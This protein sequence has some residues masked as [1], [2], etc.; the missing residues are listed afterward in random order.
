[1]AVSMLPA[2]LSSQVPTLLAVQEVSDDALV[3]LLEERP[4]LHDAV[5]VASAHSTLATGHVSAL[6]GADEPTFDRQLVND[7]GVRVNVGDLAVSS[8]PRGQLAME[9]PDEAPGDPHAIVDGYDEA[10]DRITHEIL[11]MLQ[12]SKVLVIWAFDQSESMKDDQAEIRA[13]VEK[14]YRELQLHGATQGDALLTA[15]ASF[16]ATVRLHTEKP[17]ADPDRIRAAI[18]E[19]PID[20]TGQ[21]MLCHAV[22]YLTRQFESAGTSGRRQVAL[23]LVTDESGDKQTNVDLLEAAIEQVRDAR[24]RIYVLGREA[25]FGYL[26]AHIFWRHPQTG[27]IHK[28]PIDRGPETAYAEQL[29]TNGLTRRYDSQPSGFGPY[30]QCRMVRQTGGVFFMLPSVETDIVRED[31]NAL[32]RY[33]NG[34]ISK[35]QYLQEV[36]EHRRFTLRALRPYMPSLDARRDYLAERQASPLRST[37]WTVIETLNPYDPAK[38][39]VIEMRLRFSGDPPTFAREVQTELAKAKLY[40][41]FLNLADDELHKLQAARE[42]EIYPRWQANYDLMR[43][44]VIAYRVRLHEYG[45]Y[46]QEFIKNPK[47]LPLRKEHPNQ[48]PGHFLVLAHWNV[49]HVPRTL[50]GERTRSDIARATE[51]FQAV[52]ARHPNTPWAERAE[53]ELKRG[54]G[55]ELEEEYHHVGPPPKNPPPPPPLIPLPKL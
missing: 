27:V 43:A 4:T 7:Q 14:V 35:E 25:V 8:V 26:Y 30:E 44:Q 24:C 5:V 42:K 33:Q 31:G 50:T 55:I 12:K 39:K 11:M 41:D 1:M 13:R 28:I 15:V 2:M 47:P 32:V 18:D 52:I 16:G 48:Q 34:L 38:A 6:A 29:Q 36:A 19:V 9:T 17:T 10:M 21:E 22:G 37:L 54:F 46:L 45:A 40:F 49:I 53:L 3:E 23:I 20:K 51:L